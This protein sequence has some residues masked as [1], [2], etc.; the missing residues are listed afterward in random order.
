M[1]AVQLERL[2]SQIQALSGYYTQPK[3]FHHQLALLL[4][5][6]ADLTF[7]PSPGGQLLPPAVQSFHVPPLVLQLIERALLREVT[8]DP[9][10]SLALVGELWSDS[11]LEVRQVAAS[12]LGM[13]PGE[14]L[15]QCLQRIAAWAQPDTDLLFLNDLFARGTVNLRRLAPQRWIELIGLWG[16]SSDPARQRLGILALQ[17]MINDRSF[18]NLPAVFKVISPLFHEYNDLFKNELRNALIALSRRSAN[19][20]AYFLRQMLSISSNPALVKLVR[21][22]LPEFPEEARNRLRPYLQALSR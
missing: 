11:H 5:Q 21:Q 13:L 4:E 1:P 17:P 7:R 9:G 19:E 10:A 15:E 8:A 6:H 2:K 18:T 22:C 14:Y 3:D 16:S 20:T 12:L